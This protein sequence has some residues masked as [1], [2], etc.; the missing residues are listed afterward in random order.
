MLDCLFIGCSPK[1]ILHF[2]AFWLRKLYQLK[3]PYVG[4]WFFWRPGLVVNSPEIAR[5]I[6]VKDHANFRNR[7]LSSGKS[8]PIG[9]L[10]IFTVNV[11]F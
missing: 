8:D 11:R 9:G 4:I 3:S 6:L 7:Y 2:Q 10:N 1:T 5:R